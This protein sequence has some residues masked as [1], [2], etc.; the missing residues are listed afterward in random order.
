VVTFSFENE[1]PEIDKTLKVVRDQIFEERE[2]EIIQTYQNHTR[3]IVRQ[4]LHCYHVTEEEY[5]VEENSCNIQIL[6]VEG[7]R[8]VEGPNIYLEEYVAPLKI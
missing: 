6:E 8:E 5:P 3:Q 1:S 7:E 4:L 2:F